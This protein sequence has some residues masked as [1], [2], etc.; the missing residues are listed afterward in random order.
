M[1]FAKTTLVYHKITLGTMDLYL[2]MAEE[3]RRTRT[4]AAAFCYP[5]ACGDRDASRL[6]HPLASCASP[7]VKLY[8]PHI[9]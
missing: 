6:S 8:A 2:Q 1:C 5:A 7:S 3:H 9:N 4:A